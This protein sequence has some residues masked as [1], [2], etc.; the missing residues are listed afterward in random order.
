VGGLVRR[1]GHSLSAATTAILRL[2]NVVDDEGGSWK[3]R[4]V[5]RGDNYE[6]LAVFFQRAWGKCEYGFRFAMAQKALIG[7]TSILID[8]W[9]PRKF[10]TML[11]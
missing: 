9:V 3:L 7:T 10:L 11:A 2:K 8:A 4:V 5:G 6:Q 1:H